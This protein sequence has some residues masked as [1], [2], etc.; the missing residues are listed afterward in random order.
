MKKWLISGSI[1]CTLFAFSLNTSF[2]DTPSG[3]N[4]VK[5]AKTHHERYVYGRTDCSALTRS[6]YAKVGIHLPR[7][8]RQQASVGVPIALNQLQAG[9]LV[10]FATG[11]KG[12]ISHVGIYIGNG[13]MIDAEYS[14]VRQTGIFSGST[15]CYWKS[16]YITA[17]R[18]L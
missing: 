8:S 12:V 14:G 5:I 9:D 16:K 18:V 1:A 17:R 11:R 2:A 15:A 7:T 3:S 4:I 13:K 6:V 10:F